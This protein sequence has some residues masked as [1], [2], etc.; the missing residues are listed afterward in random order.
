MSQP[1]WP[2]SIPP[3]RGNPPDDTVGI[4]IPLKDNLK[5]FK[6]AF[7]SVLSFTD[8]PYMLT[9][10]DNMSSMSTRTYLESIRKNHPINVIR[11]Q[12]EFNFSA[13]INSGMNY[14]FK[15]S[16]VKYGLALNSDVVVEPGWLSNMVQ[17]INGN[18]K[19]GISGPV[20]NIAINSQ[21]G[22]KGRDIIATDYV[23]GFCMLFKREVYET[24]NG[25]DENYHGGC[26]EDRDFCYRASNLGWRSIVDTSV[27]IH[28][29]WKATRRSDPR[30]ETQVVEN[31]NRFFSK[32]PILT[33]DP[34]PTNSIVK[35]EFKTSDIL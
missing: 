23:S 34:I 1:D 18:P 28:H 32:F 15:N 20:S 13:E 14:M 35:R 12:K 6:L 31:R 29:F 10:V 22:R 4:V 11:Y 19:W 16:G 25:F 27:Y 7:H 9:V 30:S 3:F 21:E 33:K 26:Y 24:L 17:M 8:H 2:K 5:F